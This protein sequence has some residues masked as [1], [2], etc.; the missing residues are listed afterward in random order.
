MNGWPPSSPDLNII[1]TLW[2]ILQDRVIEKQAY[3]YDSLVKTVVDEWWNIDQKLI[4]KLY[5]GI[6]TR[7]KK[8]VM[9][10]GD[11]FRI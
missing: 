3:T 2:S 11:R 5:D 9:A 6:P 8:C 7:L 4:Q 1:E 10:E